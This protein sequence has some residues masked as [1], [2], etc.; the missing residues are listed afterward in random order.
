MTIP[1]SPGDAVAG[2]GGETPQSGDERARL[3]DLHTRLIDTIDGYAKVIEK[4]EP[5]IVA[6]AEEFRDL[7][8][9]QAEKIGA[10]LTAM[11]HDTSDSGSILG[12]VNRAAVEV[13]S[14][15]GDIGHNVMD[16]IAEG[17]TRVIE[18]FEDAIVASPSIERI[19]ILEQMRGE[20]ITL[21]QRHAPGQA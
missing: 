16:A 5:E 18:A 15:F 12:M 9:G 19:A 3:A 7:H 17:E 2:T 20:I 13:R 6:I 21:L 1:M 4:A 14:W 11:G 10:L 8:Q